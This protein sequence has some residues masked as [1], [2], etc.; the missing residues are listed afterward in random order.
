MSRPYKKD[1]TYIFVSKDHDTNYFAD[2]LID[3]FLLVRCI[4]RAA[5]PESGLPRTDFNDAHDG[6]CMLLKGA[7]HFALDLWTWLAE[8]VKG[9]CSWMSLLCVASNE[10]LTIVISPLFPNGEPNP[11]AKHTPRMKQ[12]T[13]GTNRV[14]TVDLM[15][16]YIKDNPD[17]A[18]DAKAPDS[19]DTQ[20]FTVIH[21]PDDQEDDGNGDKDEVYLEIVRSQCR[22]HRLRATLESMSF[23]QH[24]LRKQTKGHGIAF[25]DFTI[26]LKGW[27]RFE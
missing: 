12:I 22:Y 8:T 13:P 15:L 3:D 16:R 17:Y 5:L 7:R 21:G 14:E 4:S 24:T 20:I 23:E 2:G 10:D 9:D 26:F 1:G 6:F 18:E 11:L 19:S 27:T 25:P